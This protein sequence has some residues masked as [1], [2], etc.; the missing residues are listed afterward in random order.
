[1]GCVFLKVKIFSEK[2][3]TP[4]VDRKIREGLCISFPQDADHFRRTRG[5][6]DIYPV[7]SLI[8]FSD[9]GRKLV[10]AHAGIVHRKILINGYGELSIFGFQNVFIHPD[11]RGRGL[12]DLLMTEIP[13]IAANGGYDCGL[14]FCVPELEKVYSGFSW[15]KIMNKEILSVDGEGIMK[16]IPAGNIAMFYPLSIRDFPDGDVNLQGYDW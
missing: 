5:W 9:D 1:M 3:I 14:L 8:V 7:H 16:P 11:F 6:H 12:L 10:I 13:G 4:E 2:E 15:K